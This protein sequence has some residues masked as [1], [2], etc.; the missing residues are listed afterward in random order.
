MTFGFGGAAKIP[1][2]E[3][4]SELALEIYSLPYRTHHQVWEA[5]Q[6]HG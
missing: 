1:L 5:I 4:L 3:V 2:A 6:L